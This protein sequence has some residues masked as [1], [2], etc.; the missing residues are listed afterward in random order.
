MTLITRILEKSQTIS[1]PERTRFDGTVVKL[2][3]RG[4]LARGDEVSSV[5]TEVPAADRA[6]WL[7]ELS[8]AL[9]DAHHVLVQLNLPSD[10]H[11]EARD[12][13]LRIEAAK[14]EIQLLRLSRSL[15]LRNE[16][17]PKGTN[18]RVL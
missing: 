17:D 6:R 10:R 15:N 7:A 12:L 4:I 8:E 13:F 18:L 9:E 1:A 16:N 3:Y 5:P 11:S 14:L 2:A